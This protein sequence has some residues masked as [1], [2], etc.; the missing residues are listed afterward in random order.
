MTPKIENHLSPLSQPH[1]GSVKKTDKQ[2]KGN[3]NNTT[4][5][6]AMANGSAPRL[7][8]FR[9]LSEKSL[10]KEGHVQQVEPSAQPQKDEFQSQH[11]EDPVVAL[12][13]ARNKH[14]VRFCLEESTET[15]QN[16]AADLKE[17]TAT[18]AEED[19]VHSTSFNIK[20]FMGR[21]LF[22]KGTS[23]T[24]EGDI[25]DNEELGKC[26]IVWESN[27]MEE[28]SPEVVHTTSSAKQS[29]FK[30]SFSENPE[31]RYKVGKLLDK[32]RRARFSHYRY[33]YAVKCYIKA[34]D[35]L[36]EAKYPEDHPLVTKTLKALNNAHHA[37]SCFDSSAN[38]VKM[39]IKYEDQNDLIRALKMYTIAFRIRRDQISRTHPS[40]VVLL[41]ILGSIQV[42]RGE[43]K[44]AMQIYELALRDAPPVISMPDND[45]VP[46]IPSSNLLARAVTFREMGIIHEKW[47]DLQEALRMYHRSLNII[48]DWREKT[49]AKYRRLQTKPAQ[50]SAPVSTS[51]ISDD[52]SVYTFNN[53]QLR[54]S[55]PAQ[56]DCEN[57]EMEVFI[58]DPSSTG[59]PEELGENMIHSYDTFFPDVKESTNKKWKRKIPS[60][61]GRDAYADVDV[62]LT[63]HQI[64]QLH[65]KQG[66]H[67]RALDAYRAALRGM[68]HALGEVHPNVAAILGNIGNLQKEMGD[69]D[70]AYD[71]YQDVLGI[72]S[73]R[74]GV[75]HP[76]VATS[77]HNVATIEAG[78]GNYQQALAIY[79]KVISLQRKLFGDDHIALAITSACMGD[80]YERLGHM[81]LAID[82]YEETLRVKTIVLGRH[83]LQVARMLHKLGKM[84]FMRK[85]YNLAKSYMSRTVLIYRLNKISDDHEWLIDAER[86]AADVEAA[87]VLGAGRFL[88]V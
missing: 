18:N 9:R 47:G 49:G 84:A 26:P 73:Y 19:A 69:L 6:K 60:P 66:Q 15:K 71:T 48:L 39:G 68:K 2:Q 64:A 86:D 57:G 17:P 41:N 61:T 75:S 38:I 74:L 65:K 59:Q 43:L 27:E 33:R 45:L 53:I 70:A 32:A 25:D 82:C 36:K 5:H 12:F 35:L 46:P 58:S 76:E 14:R 81:T 11:D 21:I 34:H 55:Y 3:E 54:K 77:L 23:I 44:E 8:L 10:K 22:N 29:S 7:G 79:Q 51:G 87:L 4:K 52:A 78:R 1:Q 85:D 63:F 50:K 20:L 16:E 13:E 80:V 37:L 88:E 62:S 28:E 24:D 42:K 83:D 31:V 56:N 40:L 72:E 30:V 67:E